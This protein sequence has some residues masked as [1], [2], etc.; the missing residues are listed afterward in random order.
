[1]ANIT[2]RYNRANLGG[3]IGV[4]GVNGDWKDVV[5]QNNDNKCVSFF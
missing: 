3:T 5:L 2:M 4:S 1:M